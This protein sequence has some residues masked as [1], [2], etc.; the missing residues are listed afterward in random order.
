MCGWGDMGS[1]KALTHVLEVGRVLE[2]GGWVEVLLWG[3]CALWGLW[4]VDTKL[5][6]LKIWVM[7]PPLLALP[8]CADIGEGDLCHSGSGLVWMLTGVNKEQLT[9]EGLR[10]C[11]EEDVRKKAFDHS[12][13]VEIG[14]RQPQV[15]KMLQRTDGKLGLWQDSAP[16][17]RNFF[18][19]PPTL[20]MQVV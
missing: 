7:S 2:L 20:V 12:E 3:H 11:S 14:S 8:P 6:H 16:T 18:G 15:K 1:V 10:V 9:T 17:R 19:T 5:P 4:S 13:L